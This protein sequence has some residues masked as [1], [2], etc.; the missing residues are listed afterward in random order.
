VEA[1]TPDR[2]LLPHL[3]DECDRGLDLSE[4]NGNSEWLK[5]ESVLNV[6]Q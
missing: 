6:C 4:G 5:S 1:E 3:A 2:G